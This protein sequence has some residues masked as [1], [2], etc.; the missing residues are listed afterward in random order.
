MRRKGLRG[1]TTLTA[2]RPLSKIL[3]HAA[4]RGAIHESELLRRSS[5]DRTH[6]CHGPLRRGRP[7]ARGSRPG[8]PFLLLH[9]GAGP[10]SMRRCPR[11]QQAH[12]RRPRVDAPLPEEPTGAVF[13]RAVHFAGRAAMS[14]RVVGGTRDV[15]S[16][17]IRRSG[18]VSDCSKPYLEGPGLAPIASRRRRSGAGRLGGASD[19]GLPAAACG[20]PPPGE[21]DAGTGRAG[22]WPLRA[23]SVAST[24]VTCT[25]ASASPHEPIPASPRPEL[26]ARRYA[27]CASARCSRR[28]RAIARLCLRS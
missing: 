15:L 8:R 28:R 1:S 14:C 18:S 13:A 26:R 19:R 11:S 16:S 27:S 20:R 22:G 17:I 21:Q 3:A 10:A 4:R 7:H 25:G 23:R 24:G 2:L 12:R 5:D 6:D 9:G